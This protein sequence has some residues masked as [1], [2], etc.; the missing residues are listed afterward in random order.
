MRGC[1]RQAMPPNKSSCRRL[2]GYLLFMAFLGWRSNVTCLLLFP[3]QPPNT[4][5]YYQ[6]ISLYPWKNESH[7]R[8]VACRNIGL[9]ED[10]HIVGWQQETSVDQRKSPGRGPSPQIFPFE[11]HYD[12]QHHIK[13]SAII[14]I[15]GGQFMSALK[16]WPLS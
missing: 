13:Y 10:V 4:C 5:N 16:T 7:L 6:P 8:W 14:S 11:V 2:N 15:T 1:R 3:E 9:A 12:A